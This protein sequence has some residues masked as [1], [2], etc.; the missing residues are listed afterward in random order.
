MNKHANLTTG[1]ITAILF[2]IIYNVSAFAFQ[3]NEIRAN[4]IRLHVIANSDS[5]EDQ[6]IKLKVRDA[7]LDAGTNIFDGTVTPDNARKKITNEI[8][9]LENTANN[10]LQKSNKTYRATVYLTTEFFDTRIYDDN[11]TLP[12]GKYL[13]LKVV[14]GEGEGKNWWCVMFPTLCLPATEKTNNNAQ[15]NTYSNAEKNII[16]N[17]DKYAIRFKLVEIIETIK[18]KV[19]IQTQRVTLYIQPILQSI[20]ITSFE[21]VKF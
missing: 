19:D 3:C 2:L 13:A 1:I 14:L 10:V 21:H 8:K 11:L 5:T 20:F 16:E 18:N 7:I 15:K 12:A 17:A 6:D 4:T 9:H